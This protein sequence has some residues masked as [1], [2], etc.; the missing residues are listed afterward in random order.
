MGAIKDNLK[1]ALVQIFENLNPNKTASEKAEEI[2]TAI[3]NAILQGLQVKIPAGNVVIG[4]VGQAT[5][6][7]NPGPIN[8]DLES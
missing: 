8:C 6:T 4:V 5:G 7:M 2:A 1:T 3:E